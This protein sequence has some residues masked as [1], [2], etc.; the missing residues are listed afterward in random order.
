MHCRVL[1]RV[2]GNSRRR[3]WE[4]TGLARRGN[5]G[6]GCAWHRFDVSLEKRDAHGTLVIQSI[7]RVFIGVYMT[8]NR[9]GVQQTDR[10]GRCLV[11]YHPDVEVPGG[12]RWAQFELENE[13]FFIKGGDLSTMTVETAAPIATNCLR[14]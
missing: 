2:S 7:N 1:V 10:L 11:S 8:W 14:L 4:A 9:A 13:R 3:V 6:Y 5:L 12:I